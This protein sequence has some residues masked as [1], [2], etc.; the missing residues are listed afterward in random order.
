MQNEETISEGDAR[1]GRLSRAMETAKL[2]QSGRLRL[3]AAQDHG[4]ESRLGLDAAESANRADKPGLASA[5]RQAQAK[6]KIKTNEEYT[7]VLEQMILSLTGMELEELHEAVGDRLTEMAMTAPYKKS[8]MA[9]YSQ[10][11]DTFIDSGFT[12]EDALEKQI[13]VEK[14][15]KRHGNSRNLY[16][17]GGKVL[18]RTAAQKVNGFISSLYPKTH[19]Q[20]KRALSAGQKVNGFIKGLYK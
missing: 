6:A 8:L 7:Q 15:L 3:G 19:G 4:S 5:L 10:H 11:N 20:K 2:R 12:D 9:Q 1:L 17:M 16:G 13:E 14:T 18:K